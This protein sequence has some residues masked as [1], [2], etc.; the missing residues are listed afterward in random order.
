MHAFLKAVP[1][2]EH[3]MQYGFPVRRLTLIS[4]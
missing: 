1:K 3:H 4:G 2:C